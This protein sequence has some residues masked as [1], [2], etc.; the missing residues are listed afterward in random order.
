MYRKIKYCIEKHKKE[1]GDMGNT[2][3]KV[4]LAQYVY[5]YIMEMLI[6]GEIKPGEK[7]PEE[8]ITKLLGV[9]RTPIRE[10]MRLLA[11]EGLVNIYPNR[12]AEVVV[13]TKEDIH[14]LGIIRLN[15][16]MLAGRFAIYNGSNAD[17]T[18]L[19]EIADRCKEYAQ[20]GDV[21]NRIVYDNMFHNKLTD[22]GGNPILSR[23]QKELYQKIC[24]FQSMEYSDVED[25]LQKISHHDE[26]IQAL[27]N[28]DEKEYAQ[29]IRQHLIKFYELEDSKYKVF[30]SQ[31]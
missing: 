14:D 10:A 3:E 31:I 8:K 7:V 11:A 20:K 30:L 21:Y 6:K 5:H 22:I 13:L 4:N 15:N 28:R 2:K 27:V 1:D 17:F 12:F 26:I 9:S 19:A 16:D 18:E 29:A 25:S 23:L 24:L